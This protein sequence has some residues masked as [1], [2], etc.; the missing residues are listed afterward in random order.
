M[1]IEVTASTLHGSVVAPSSKSLSHRAII[2]AAL[3]H[4]TSILTNALQAEDIEQTIQ[5]LRQLGVTIDIQGNS[6]SIQGSGGKLR[7]PDKAIYLGAS[8]SSLRFLTAV[9]GLVQ[10]TIVLTGEKRL[11]ERPMADMI[12]PLKAMGIK[13]RSIMNNGRA[14]IEVTGGQVIGGR[15]TVHANVSSQFASALLLIAPFAKTKTTIHIVD[16]RSKPYI[17]LTINVMRDFG[18]DVIKSGDDTF[19]IGP[20]QQYQA[21]TYAIE[22]DYSSSSYF[23]A[24]AAVTGSSITL[25]NLNTH[26]IQGDRYFLILLEKMGCKI[27]SR[28]GGITITPVKRLRAITADLGNCPDIVQSLAVVAAFAGGTT[29]IKNIGHLKHKETDRLNATATELRKMGIQAK[30]DNDSL[31]ITGGTPKGTAID[32]YNDHRMAM[33]FAVAGLGAVGTTVVH[34]VE[35]IK[36]S[37]PELFKDLTSL[38]ANIKET[39]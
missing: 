21:R 31:I 12:E 36:K 24:A 3:A 11:C 10:G 9:A 39:I 32:T 35:V 25:K 15:I 22:G 17:E 18:I 1:N 28:D 7:A 8:G 4:G 23:F 5:A 34:N 37:Y 27:A 14:P 2:V 6:L 33:S 13:I 38:G 26:S 16:A 20:H 29:K 19:S 30:N